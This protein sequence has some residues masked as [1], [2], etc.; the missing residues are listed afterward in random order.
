METIE[1]FSQELK[2]ELGQLEGDLLCLAFARDIGR[3]TF[4]Y[5]ETEKQLHTMAKPVQTNVTRP[6]ERWADM[7]D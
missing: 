1:R 2:L 7:K 5:R 4:S 3:V 6:K